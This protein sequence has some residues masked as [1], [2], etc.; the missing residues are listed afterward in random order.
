MTSGETS[1]Q[2]TGAIGMF[3]SG[4]GGLT[5]MRAL[6]QRLP[7]EQIVYFGD[8]AR[9]P[10]GQKSPETIR[11]YSL[12]N[13]TFLMD[14]QIK[15]LVVACNTASAWALES[16]QQRFHLPVVG[17]ITPSAAK[18]A[19]ATSNGRIA[20]M[21]TKSTIDSGVYQ[22]ELKH[23]RLTVHVTPI[24]GPMLVPLVEEG[25]LDHPATDLFLREYLAPAIEA[26][27][28]TIL[29]GCTHYPLLSEAIQ[30]IVGPHVQLIDSTEACAEAVAN[31]LQQ[32]R[33]QSTSLK[34]QTPLF[35]ASDDPAKFAL[36]G[37]RFLGKPLQVAL[38]SIH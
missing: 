26:K 15:V 36:L 24:V 10:Y 9:V 28:D 5:V 7:H 19:V 13:A 38:R 11:R 35:Y 25:L 31:V 20:V 14:Q 18:A 12:E 4:L 34:A 30:R 2:A 22:K 37:E 3:D 33:L 1:T 29:L 27:V 21:A 8:T 6:Q 17:V 16:L 32:H 23:H